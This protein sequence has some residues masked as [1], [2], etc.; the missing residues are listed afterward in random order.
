MGKHISENE[1]DNLKLLQKKGLSQAE[2][3]RVTERSSSLV[4]RVYNAETWDGYKGTVKLFNLERNHPEQLEVVNEVESAQPELEDHRIMDKLQQIENHLKVQ[5][6][7]FS[8]FA[9]LYAWV[10]EHAKLD[11]RKKWGVL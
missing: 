5:D 6:Q 9:E 4:S 7:Q 8:E 3:V 10:A 2:A 11:T 1:F